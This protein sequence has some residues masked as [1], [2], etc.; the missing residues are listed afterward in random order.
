MA[1]LSNISLLEEVKQGKR[2]IALPAAEAAIFK[3]LLYR[4]GYKFRSRTKNKITTL[5]IQ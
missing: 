4:N 1:K 5:Q 2:V 3:M